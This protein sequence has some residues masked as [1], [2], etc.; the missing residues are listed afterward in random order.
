MENYDEIKAK[1][2]NETLDFASLYAKYEKEVETKYFFIIDEINRADLSKVFGELM[3]GLE[4]SYRGIQNSFQTQYQNLKSYEIN[5]NGKA[6]KMQF[7]CFKDGFFI[8]LNLYIIGTMN[9]ID[10]SV[11]AFDFALR[12]RFEW[13]DIKAKEVCKDSLLQMVDAKLI[14]GKKNDAKKLADKINAMNDVI[15]TDGREFGLSDAYHIGHAYFKG[16]I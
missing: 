14:V 16:V 1:H 5:S 12:R 10:K 13:I 8:P 9:D 3:Y 7:D 15:S 11:E 4:E 6:E 2:S